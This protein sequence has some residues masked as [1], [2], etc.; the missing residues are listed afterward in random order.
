MFSRR[1]HEIPIAMTWE[2]QKY[3]YIRKPKPL[4]Y[5]KGINIL[6]SFKHILQMYTLVVKHENYN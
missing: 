3:K 4:R 1:K 6:M 2:H 5:T